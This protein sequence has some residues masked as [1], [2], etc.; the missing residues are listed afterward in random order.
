MAIS[1]EISSYKEMDNKSTEDDTSIV[2]FLSN[3]RILFNENI[4]SFF[5]NKSLEKISELGDGWDENPNNKAF[6]IDFLKKIDN[7]LVRLQIQLYSNN[8]H[9]E[10]P[11]ISVE[12]S[13]SIDLHWKTSKYQILVNF[14]HNENAISG[15]V[16]ARVFGTDQ[17]LTIGGTNKQI[18]EILERWLVLALQN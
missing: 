16:Y 3:A 15:T 10:K 13:D 12:N 11:I 14:Q 2:L 4:L 17:E 5:H 1:S 18:E 6:R 9:I 8:I 7:F